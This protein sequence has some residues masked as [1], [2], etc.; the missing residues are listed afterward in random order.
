MYGFGLLYQMIGYFEVEEDH[1]C[2]NSYGEVKVWLNND[3]SKNYPEDYNEQI[4]SECDMVH[5]ILT[6][7]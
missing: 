2:I 5:K 4:K 3:L 1:I 6:L 7:I